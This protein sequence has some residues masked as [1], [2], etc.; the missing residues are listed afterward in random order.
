MTQETLKAVHEFLLD[1]LPEGF[2]IEPSPSYESENENFY[3]DAWFEGTS[4]KKPQLV[5][6]DVLAGKIRIDVV[7]R[8]QGGPDYAWFDLSDPGSQTK[9]RTYFNRVL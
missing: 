8:D 5:F 6:I 7:N 3:F 2:E 9:I 1:A 4:S